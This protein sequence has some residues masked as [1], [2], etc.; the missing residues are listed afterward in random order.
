MCTQ[1]HAQGRAVAG[2]PTNAVLAADMRVKL[3]AGFAQ[4]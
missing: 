2:M 4:R 3:I 1:A